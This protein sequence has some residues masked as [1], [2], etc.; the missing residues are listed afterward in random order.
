MFAVKKRLC[1]CK[2][3]LNGHYKCHTPGAHAEEAPYESYETEYLKMILVELL[4]YD[5]IPDVHLQ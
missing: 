2:V 3:S 1:E 5:I 4:C